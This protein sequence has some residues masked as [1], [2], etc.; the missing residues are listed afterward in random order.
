MDKQYLEQRVKT[1]TKNS[2]NK[3]AY[4]SLRACILGA[5]G[6]AFISTSSLYVALKLGALP[7]PIIFLALCSYVI[8]KALGKTSLQE[9]T[10]AH[11]AMSAG[12]I[13]SGALA[14]TIPG[15]WILDA[16]AHISF[17]KLIITVASGAALGLIFSA[18]IRKHFIENN[19][20]VFPMGQ[21]A[22]NT[23]IAADEGGSKAG[24]LFASLSASGLVVLLRDVLHVLPKQL[25]SISV[26]PMIFAMGFLAGPLSCLLWACGAFLAHLFLMSFL[27]KLGIFS[28]AFA[29]ELRSSLGIGCML[30]CGLGLILKHVVP[31]ARD[32]F[33]PL[34][35][36][37][38][39]DSSIVPL[40]WAP[41]VSALLVLCL[42]VILDFP[43]VLSMLCIG[44]SWIAVS[45]S[46]QS[47]ADS[48]INPL[49]VFAIIM[50]VIAR[51]LI[52]LLPLE[53]FLF[54]CV[55][56]VAC[57]LA[58]DMM[59]DFKAGQL[60]NTSAR[61]QWLAQSL[62]AFVGVFVSTAVLLILVKA[63][64]T[65]AFG[66]GKEFI[67]LQARVVASMVSGSFVGWGLFLG[68]IVGCLLYFVKL[69]AM[70]FGLGLYLPL[71]MSLAAC[72]GGLLR[73]I[74]QQVHKYKSQEKSLEQSQEQSSD[75]T[76]KAYDTKLVVAASGILGGEAVLSVLLALYSVVLGLLS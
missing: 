53:A 63:Y 33:A 27:V 49:E 54:T 24:V 73:F 7:S 30:G 29:G 69:P 25:M 52:P 18:L 72:L 39:Q 23:L 19:S 9:A 47:V 31:K 76:C 40:R 43:F 22:A 65:Q 37:S 75:D 55:I 46:A 4:L 36:K 74:L 61:E 8:L 50:L 60:V 56:A 26:S 2:L 11:T 41:F 5:L 32:I 12:S 15:I 3:A 42:C 35:K 38:A 1:D 64:G 28:F 71:N 34:Y 16:A 68:L 44:G 70:T 10:L 17:I 6:A 57:G 14:F 66:E 21:A 58:G 45:M 62:G 67:A 20:L 13:I 48:G 59:S 51:L